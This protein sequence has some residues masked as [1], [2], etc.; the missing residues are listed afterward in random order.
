MRVNERTFFKRV[1]LNFALVIAVLNFVGL[2]NLYSAS[3]N[4]ASGASM[5]FFKQI[6]WLTAGWFIY[7]VLTVIDY[8]VFTRIAWFL[9]G[10]NLAALAAVEFVGKTYY[11]A[12]RWLDLG[13]FRY[14]PSETMK[15]CLILILAKILSRKAYEGGMGFKDLVFPLII[16][17]VPFLLTVKQPDL[18]TAL[19]F[20]AIAGSMMLFVGVKRRIIV[21]AAIIGLIT[22]PVAW[23]FGL[24]EYQKRRVRTFLTPGKDPRGAGYNSIQSKIAV[25]SG[26]VLGKGFRKGSQSQLEFLPER[27]T[28]FIFSVL[29]EEHGFLGSLTTVSLFAIL[30]IKII[31]IASQARERFGAI[32]TVGILAF[33]FW[34][35]FVNVGMVIGILPIVGVPLP[36]LSYGGSILIATM[37]GL[38]LISAVSYRRYLF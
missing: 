36:L 21:T 19:L 24:K 8:K 22:V 28:D 16:T 31:G 17:G 5:I 9:Y 25:G 30:F 2:V 33:I 32:M 20:V 12:Q 23:Q 6:G 15:L 29:S 35:M 14:Q 11:G 37:V 13:F 27:H 18:G 1:D 7:F 34:H 10:L 3:S 4:D 26:K 38:G